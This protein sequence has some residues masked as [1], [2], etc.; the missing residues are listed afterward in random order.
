MEVESVLIDSFGRSRPNKTSGF[1]NGKLLVAMPHM[2]DQSLSQ[3]VIY[4]C[5]HDDN[6]AIGL[7][8]NKILSTISFRD[9]LF[10][11][12]IIDKND[13]VINIPVHFGGPVEVGRGFVLHTNDYIQETTV[14]MEDG[15]ALTA[16]LD[17]LK[18]ISEGM[19]PSNSLLALGYT[20]WGTG[21]LEQEI[22]NN[23]WLVVNASPEIVFNKDY[24]STWLKALG[25]LGINPSNISLDSGN[26]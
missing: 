9:L 8:I 1:L 20:G 3:A 6:G 5:G 2:D 19:G 25:S 11:L 16:T 24:E 12:G 17:I 22:Q 23:G 15:F 26:A 21:Q 13:S 18:I 10:Q 7:V 14:D 4:I